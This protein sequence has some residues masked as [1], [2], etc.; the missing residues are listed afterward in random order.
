MK[1]LVIAPPRSG[2]G[3]ASKALKD[4]GFDVGHERLRKNGISSW[5][6]A[7]DCYDNARWGHNYQD[8][9]PDKT[10][11]LARN[12]FDLV[13]SMAFSASNAFEWMGQYV[14]YDK[15][16]P[17]H[18]QAA[19]LARGWIELCLRRNPDHIVRTECLPYFCKEEFGEIPDENLKGYNT[20]KHRYLSKTEANDVWYIIKGVWDGYC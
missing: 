1:I 16:D 6:W 10:I 5:L 17:I 9:K 2:T 8:I 20:R 12:E 15:N 7:V 4:I 11:L 18:I 3:Y 19:T 14:P 13:A